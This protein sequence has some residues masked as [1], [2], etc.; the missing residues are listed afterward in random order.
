MRESWRKRG[1]TRISAQ[2]GKDSVFESLASTRMSFVSGVII[3]T[4]GQETHTMHTFTEYIVYSLT[5]AKRKV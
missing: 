4:E 3:Y 5:H 2:Y 1:Q